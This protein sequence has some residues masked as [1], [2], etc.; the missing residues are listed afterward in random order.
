MIIKSEKDG[1]IKI[2][3]NVDELV[4]GMSATKKPAKSWLDVEMNKL[5]MRLSKERLL[6][7]GLC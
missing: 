7:D 4:E 5:I 3:D 2:M 6:N 1:L